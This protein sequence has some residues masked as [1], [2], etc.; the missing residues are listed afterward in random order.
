MSP[1]T[2]PTKIE[3]LLRLQSSLAHQERPHEAKFCRLRKKSRAGLSYRTRIACVSHRTDAEVAS[4]GAT[5]ALPPQKLVRQDAPN[6]LY[7]GGSAVTGTAWHSPSNNSSVPAPAIIHTPLAA[8]SS[9]SDRARRLQPPISAAQAPVVTGYANRGQRSHAGVAL[10]ELDVQHQGQAL[11]ARSDAGTRPSL[12]SGLSAVATVIDPSAQAML[13][14][15]ALASASEA[16]E[17]QPVSSSSTDSSTRLQHAPKPQMQGRSRG[18]PPRTGRS[19]LST[20]KE[21]LLLSQLA[22]A[23]TLDRLEAR[24]TKG[25]L[26]YRA[27]V[28]LLLQ[29]GKLAGWPEGQPGTQGG[30]VS[31]SLVPGPGFPPP[32]SGPR[33]SPGISLHAEPGPG[34]GNVSRNV[35][36]SAAH[37]EQPGTRPEDGSTWPWSGGGLGLSGTSL[38]WAGQDIGPGTS[39][40][41]LPDPDLGLQRPEHPLYAWEDTGVL[42]RPPPSTSH[43]L[44]RPRQMPPKGPS[45][46]PAP[47]ERQHQARPRAK[48][49]PRP[50]ISPPAPPFCIFTPIS[51]LPPPAAVATVEQD[52][53][54]PP[55]ESDVN[56]DVSMN[57]KALLTRTDARQ[58]AASAVL[59]PLSGK[60]N[61]VGLHSQGRERE[62]ADGIGTGPSTSARAW[63]SASARSP[64]GESVAFASSGASFT[65][66]PRGRGPYYLEAPSSQPP[67][68]QWLSHMHSPGTEPA[69]PG[70]P[71]DV[72]LGQNMATASGPGSGTGTS[73]GSRGNGAGAGPLSTRDRVMRPWESASTRT[74]P[75]TGTGQ[76]TESRNTAT[77]P[78]SRNTAAAPLF[79]T[80]A[81][82]GTSLE[83][84]RAGEQDVDAAD[85][86]AAP[87][88]AGVQWRL[89]NLVEEAV[90]ERL[91]NCSLPQALALCS[92]LA[93]LTP[94][95]CDI[96]E[97]LADLAG[98]G[99]SLSRHLLASLACTLARAAGTPPR[100]R[101]AGAGAAEAAGYG[102]PGWQEDV[103]AALAVRRADLGPAVL[104]RVAASAALAAPVAPARNAGL[105]S[106]IF[107]ASGAAL[108]RMTWRQLAVTA[109]A[110]ASPSAPFPPPD[111]WA[112]ELLYS[113]EWASWEGPGGAT[114]LAATLAAVAQA[115][116]AAA[117]PSGLGAGLLAATLGGLAELGPGELARLAWAASRLRLA[118][119][120]AWTQEL[121]E[122]L[123]VRLADASTDDLAMLAPALWRLN[124]AEAQTEASTDAGSTADGDQRPGAAALGAAWRAAFVHRAIALLP[125]CEPRHMSRLV[126]AVGRLPRA[127]GP[128]RAQNRRLLAVYF[129]CSA[130]E[131]AHMSPA[132]LIG[133]AVGLGAMRVSP[134]PAWAA[135]FASAIAP[136][137]RVLTPSNTAALMW[138]LA[139][140]APWPW[141]GP[142]GAERLTAALV[143]RS[144]RLLR[145]MTP[146]DVAKCAWALGALH[147]RP[148]HRWLVDCWSVCFRKRGI[149]AMPAKSL[150]NLLWAFA[151]LDWVPM[152]W[153]MRAAAAAVHPMLHEFKPQDF[154]NLLWA[155]SRLAQLP[156]DGWMFDFVQ[157]ARQRLPHFSPPDV[158]MSLTALSRVSQR[159]GYT[160][161]PIFVAELGARAAQLAPVLTGEEA[162]VALLSLVSLRHMPEPWVLSALTGTF[163]RD[164]A[165]AGGSGAATAAAAAAEGKL[166]WLSGGAAGSGPE[167]VQEA[168]LPPVLAPGV[169]SDGFAP[170]AEA[171]EGSGRHSGWRLSLT[172][173]ELAAAAGGAPSLA[174]AACLAW[175]LGT[176]A[177]RPQGGQW[178]ASNGKVV[179]SVLELTQPLLP[180]ANDSDLIMLAGALAAMGRKPP[181]A[182]AAVFDTAAVRLAPGLSEAQLEQLV[183]AFVL[184]EWRPSHRLAAAAARRKADLVAERKAVQGQAAQG[185]GAAPP[186]ARATAIGGTVAGPVRGKTASEGKDTK[187]K[188]P[189]R[190][191][192]SPKPSRSKGL[193]RLE[194]KGVAQTLLDVT[195][196]LGE[197]V[198]PGGAGIGQ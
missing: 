168:P 128:A 165:A 74:G 175:A 105:W 8:S 167:P 5:S 57:A 171:G 116:G 189:V 176:A 27:L 148:P 179:D 149:E 66:L 160:P 156:N 48:M 2:R 61:S 172:A 123:T 111:A 114:A 163:L 18:R 85:D 104:A 132:D 117:L 53:T 125:A 180:C 76:H 55:D 16:M 59:L 107:A 186:V 31:S 174:A 177:R 196:T 84:R 113:C 91:E 119:P 50:I 164:T 110:A 155:L 30:S 131:L 188:G 136:C 112:E 142:D 6:Q 147:L 89:L 169:G 141:A 15:S 34:S 173:S 135:A 69:G 7:P 94:L 1:E 51:V 64:H 41:R 185:V 170:A 138:A 122:A 162:S 4:I 161:D 79:S 187:A 151:R 44:T 127:G 106:G 12:A 195:A 47:L 157:H 72:V 70:P 32:G 120:G 19:L 58:Q 82:S 73:N 134:A 99:A 144:G 56:A 68:G 93:R 40:R 145:H 140:T 9:G 124:R 129:A 198:G 197:G 184:L 39:H 143:V 38:A 192:W 109:S 98:S 60:D 24:A 86:E 191:R 10:S 88:V 46:A 118:I 43:P 67:N 71:G 90:R 103:G 87:S 100:A 22:S 182:W 152:K 153:S 14:G 49:L 133:A 183:D 108:R 178:L 17:Q 35:A 126:L 190:R 95:P 97:R 20:S 54:S 65:H 150:V 181:P 62:Q 83:R 121:L 115:P 45:P 11:A 158:V 26:S 154:S 137:I 13:R 193:Q 25:A 28:K 146:V 33:S 75:I 80:M 3:H 77:A 29:M 96:A 78:E 166:G 81:G 42:Q 139:A 194:D 36:G 130:P 101:S 159:L 102:P 52:A 92:L 63:E 21:R 23:A 37:R